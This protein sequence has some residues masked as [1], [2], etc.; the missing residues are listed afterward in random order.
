M[1]NHSNQKNHKNHSSDKKEV[2]NNKKMIK[3][4]ELI[5][6]LVIVALDLITKIAAYNCLPFRQDVNIIGDKVIFYLTLNEDSTGVWADEL[7]QNENNKNLTVILSCIF[8]LILLSYILFIK[9]KKIRILYKIL[10]GVALFFIMSILLD[11]A[12]RLLV[13]L[14]ISS[15]ITSVLGIIFGLIIWGTIFYFVK[16]KLIRY[17]MILVIACGVGNLISH[18]YP[19]F[20]IIDFIYID[21]L[22]EL[23]KIGIFNLADLS[24]KIGAIALVISLLIWLIR[25][26]MRRY[27]TKTM[28]KHRAESLKINSVG[29]HPTESEYVSRHCEARSNPDFNYGE[30]D[31]IKNQAGLNHNNHTNQK[32]QSSDK[33][34]KK[35][36]K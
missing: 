18:F 31:I 27:F 19:P 14:Y 10:I 33:K 9:S 34:S 21:G 11:I 32:N 8:G 30:F 29:H 23:V 1:N 4:R 17:S 25:K 2:I 22:Y 16:D 26:L 20:F 15:W 5:T 36:R 3:K 6:L 24:Y 28:N 13:N 12:T 35:I 7:Y